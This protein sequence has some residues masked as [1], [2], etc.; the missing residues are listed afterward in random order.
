MLTFGNLLLALALGS[1]SSALAAYA[2]WARGDRQFRRAARRGLLGLAG[3][4]LAAGSVHLGNILTHQFAVAYVTSFSDRSLPLLLLISTFWAGQAGSLLLWAVWS[5]IFGAV[6]AWNLRRSTWEPFV[7]APYLLVAVTV[8]GLTLASN[9]FRMLDPVPADGNGLNPL[10]QNY[11][12]AIHP[13]ILFTGFT[14]MAGP[15][16]FAV[17]ALWKRDVDGWVHFARPWTIL[18]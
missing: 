17:A 11:W 8:T 1:G 3:C 15:F 10:L 9:P 5:V 16:A 13:P 14:T 7:M 2:L 18:A 6:P 12:M 4:V